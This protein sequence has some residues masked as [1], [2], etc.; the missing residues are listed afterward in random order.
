M[1]SA[2]CHGPTAQHSHHDIELH[3]ELHI[4][5]LHT[6][7]AHAAM[8]HAKHEPCRLGR[9][10]DIDIDIGTLTVFA[11]KQRSPCRVLISPR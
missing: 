8:A 10:N 11:A 1:S 2:L 5:L 7:R 9:E 3:I 6:Q 4:E